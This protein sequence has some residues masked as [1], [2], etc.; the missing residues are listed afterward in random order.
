MFPESQ[1]FVAV[2]VTRSNNFVSLHYLNRDKLGYVSL[3]HLLTVIATKLCLARNMFT[4][5]KT[6]ENGW[7]NFSENLRIVALKLLVL[8]R[9]LSPNQYIYIFLILITLILYGVMVRCDRRRFS[10]L[11]PFIEKSM[12]GNK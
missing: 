8:T 1:G 10:V 7:S 11:S 3:I 2:L 12:V 9:S 6:C 5:I 4:N